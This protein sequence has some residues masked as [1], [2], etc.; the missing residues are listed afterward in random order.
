MRV[1]SVRSQ[2]TA[3][4]LHKAGD[5]EGLRKESFSEQRQNEGKPPVLVILLGPTVLVSL[6]IP[7][8]RGSRAG[9]LEFR[10]SG[11]HH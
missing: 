8:P 7:G 11:D 10:D 9:S 6:I 2:W 1:D 4:S 3:G 5:W